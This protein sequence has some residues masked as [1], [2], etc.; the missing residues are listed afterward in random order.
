V[1]RGCFRRLAVL[2]AVAAVTALGGVAQAAHAAEGPSG[3]IAYVRGG[4]APGEELRAIQADG[5]GDRLIWKVTGPCFSGI[6]SVSWRPDGKEIAFASDHDAARSLYEMDLYAVKPD[7]AGLRRLT[8]PPDPDE[9]RAYRTGKLV[10]TVHNQVTNVGPVLVYAAGALQPQILPLPANASKTVTFDVADYG[11]H[12]HAVAAIFGKTRWII[13]GAVVHAGQTAQAGVL[14]ITPHGFEHFGATNPAWRSDGS[15]VGYILARGA[16]I[17]WTSA[18]PTPGTVSGQSVIGG[19]GPIGAH[20]FDWGPTPATADQ[21]VYTEGVNDHV[22]RRTREGSGERGEP[23]VEYRS[24]EYVGGVW[25]LPDASGI[26]Y[27]LNNLT[28]T[29]IYRYDFATKQAKQLTRLD[30]ENAYN[31]SP[32]PDG[33]WI[34]FDRGKPGDKHT[35][36]WI[37]RSD[38]SDMRLLVRN[39]VLPVWNP[40][41]R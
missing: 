8:N 25:W 14:N 22:I 24:T 11:D 39:A 28:N 20:T 23:I 2:W 27:S 40:A 35:D 26:L 4:K 32:S 7:G 30:G 15:K 33:R 31:C 18:H 21:V 17:F 36:I 12:P 10:V 38:G 5:T 9:L 1:R 3:T 34:A 29:E 6:D 41:R 16:G 13:P 37:M 19:K